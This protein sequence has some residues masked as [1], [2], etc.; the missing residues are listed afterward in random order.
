MKILAFTDLHANI[1]AYEKL[2]KKVKKFKPDII[3]CLGD[4]SFFE[5]YLEQVLRKLNELKKPVFIIHGN[6]E[7]D[8]ILKKL[9]QRYPY[10]IFAHNKVTSVGPY[11]IIAHGGGGF[12]TQGKSAKDK[13]FERL[14]KNNKKKLRGKLILLTHAPPRKTKLDHISWAGHVGCESYAEFIRKYKPVIAL[15]GHLHE[16]FRKQQKKGK[17]IICNPGPEGMVFSI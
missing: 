16:N 3:F 2:K 14:I 5:Q 17:T 10:L 6:H 13:D 1:I 12:Y 15:S 9:C 8:T 11:T 7:T 4:V